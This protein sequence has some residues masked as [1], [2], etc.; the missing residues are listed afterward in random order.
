MLELWNQRQETRTIGTKAL[1]VKRRLVE[2]LGVNSIQVINNSLKNMNQEQIRS[3]PVDQI[4]NN[5]KS[6]MNNCGQ[7]SVSSS[8]QGNQQIIGGLSTVSQVQSNLHQRQQAI[9]QTYNP[10]LLIQNPGPIVQGQWNKAK[11]LQLKTYSQSQSPPP[12]MQPHHINTANNAYTNQIQVTFNQNM[13]IKTDRNLTEQPN[14]NLQR[15]LLSRNMNGPTFINHNNIKS[16]VLLT[17]NNSQEQ[18]MQYQNYINQDITSRTVN[19]KVKPNHQSNKSNQNVNKTFDLKNDKSNLSQLID[20][21]AQN[22]LSSDHINAQNFEA[23]AFSLSPQSLNGQKIDEWGLLA[24]YQD[25]KEQQ[26]TMQ[27][28]Q[29]KM[30]QKQNFKQNLDNHTDLKVKNTLYKK[31]FDQVIDRKVV[32]YDMNMKQK[33]DDMINKRNLESRAKRRDLEQ[34]ELKMR[35]TIIQE[36]KLIKQ[37]EEQGYLQYLSQ[38]EG[39]WGEIQQKERE[40]INVSRRMIKE[41]LD[42]QLEIKQ[43]RRQKL[44]EDEK[45]FGAVFNAKA[46]LDNQKRQQ[47]LIKMNKYINQQDYKSLPQQL[48]KQIQDKHQRIQ[49][50]VQNDIS[51]AEQVKKK[52]QEYYEQMQQ[53]SQ[54]KQQQVLNLKQLLQQQIKSNSKRSMGKGDLNYSALNGMNERERLLNK[55]Q[56]EEMY[57]AYQN[58][59]QVQGQNSQIANSDANILNTRQQPMQS[60][61]RSENRQASKAIVNVQNKGD[62]QGISQI[63]Q[64]VQANGKNPLRQSES[65]L[66]DIEFELPKIDLMRRNREFRP[67]Q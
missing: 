61:S 65:K 47:N 55:Q 6:S 57:H 66:Q 11:D 34:R 48:D 25:F 17:G 50:I 56:L 21:S 36:N 4:V 3:L 37:Q 14:P 31:A 12:Q 1:E 29:Q 59:S 13:D 27:E 18:T 9:Y 39:Q 53:Q 63:G 33:H 26:R 67:I 28:R 8:E 15:T 10:N 32:E 49:Q 44:Q 60:Q 20:N 64:R 38:Q 22:L 46:E 2:Q 62:G 7:G 52:E 43:Q 42:M 51:Y 45:F 40:K 30:Q 16:S 41:G 24:K 54:Q 35:S 58:M 5:L 19:N 23:R